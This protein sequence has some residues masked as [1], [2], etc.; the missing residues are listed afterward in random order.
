MAYE[1]HEALKSERALSTMAPGYLQ[2]LPK[3]FTP[4]NSHFSCSL[5]ILSLIHFLHSIVYL[6]TITQYI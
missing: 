5:D 4:L 6:F 1:V 2:G 3:R